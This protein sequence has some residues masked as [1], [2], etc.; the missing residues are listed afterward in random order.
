[1]SSKDG[2]SKIFN[3]LKRGRGES[4]EEK[5][6]AVAFHSV[7]DASEEQ[8]DHRVQTWVEKKG[9]APRSPTLA[10][11]GPKRRVQ[12]PGENSQN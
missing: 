8:I 12:R 7:G 5:S 11:K 6:E 9:G 3:V 2:S 4:K 1:M 10:L